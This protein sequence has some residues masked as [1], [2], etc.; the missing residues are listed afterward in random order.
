MKIKFFALI[1]TL[2]ILAACGSSPPEPNLDDFAWCY[3]FDFINES[4]TLSFVSGFATANGLESSSGVLGVSYNH[5]FIIEPAYISSELEVITFNNETRNVAGSFN[6][7]GVEANLQADTQSVVTTISGQPNNSSTFGS[8]ASVSIS[9]N[10]DS[11]VRVRTLNVYG[12]N[13]SNPFGAENCGDGS[14]A[15]PSPTETFQVLPSPTLSPTAT[16]TPTSTPTSTATNTPE[17]DDW[18]YRFDFTLNDG[19]WV[20]SDNSSNARGTYV[21]GVGWQ[22]AIHT[23]FNNPHLYIER[24]FTA[25]EINDWHVGYYV[26]NNPDAGV[27]QSFTTQSRL[28]G[29]ANAS[30]NH[31]F[32]ADQTTGTRVLFTNDLTDELY[33]VIA[34]DSPTALWTLTFVDVRGNGVNPFGADNCDLTPDPPTVEPTPEPAWCYQFNFTQNNGGWN[35]ADTSFTNGEQNYGQYSPS[36]GWQSNL[37]RVAIEIAI[38]SR[39]IYSVETTGATRTRIYSHSDPYSEGSSDAIAEG[40]DSLMYGDSTLAQSVWVENDTG[41][42]ITGV[43]LTGNF[44]NPFGA[45]NCVDDLPTSTPLSTFTPMPTRTAMATPTIEPTSTPNP[46]DDS[47]SF[48]SDG[49]CQNNAGAEP[50]DDTNGKWTEWLFGGIDKLVRCVVMPPINFIGNIATQTLAM[51]GSIFDIASNAFAYGQAAMQWTF[52]RLF[53]YIGAWVGNFWSFLSYHIGGFFGSIFGLLSGVYELIVSLINAVINFVRTIIDFI[54][55]GFRTVSRLFSLWNTTQPQ[56]PDGLPDCV[57]DPLAYD[58][59]A[60]WYLLEHTFFAGI[61]SFII[62]ALNVLII[63]LIALF[64]LETVVE[65]MQ[66]LWEV[67][68][69]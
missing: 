69:D 46:S 62:P 3:Q 6:I 27:S 14:T 19:G 22:P 12:R 40:T 13:G 38:P 35:L 20:V 36:I 5:G 61:G 33:I 4:Y 48:S 1:T 7:F 9:T 68:R 47:N 55:I 8:T 57:G 29:S 32:P 24:N 10:S 45:D 30:F 67:L 18:C 28:S 66:K 11:T 42:T 26:D 54:F 16:N 44:S 56:K 39:L 52:N 2:F 58:I 64:F 50:S 53:P 49:T 51:V 37:G 60:V 43:T 17:D 25:T 34:H 23:G 65:R 59:C 15:T 63:L 41:G 31:S 21:P